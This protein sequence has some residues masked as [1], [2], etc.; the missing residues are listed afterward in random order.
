MNNK[1]VHERIQLGDYKETKMIQGEEK[2]SIYREYAEAVV[3]AL[4]Q[5][6]LDYRIIY[7]PEGR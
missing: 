3:A 2:Q 7:N 5:Y 1:Q 4:K 6:Y